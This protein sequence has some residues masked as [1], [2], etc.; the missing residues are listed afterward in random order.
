VTEEEVIQASEETRQKLFQEKYVSHRKKKKSKKPR[1]MIDANILVAGT[2]FPRFF[3][4]VLQHA[5]R[6]DFYLVLTPTIIKEARQ[7]IKEK[8]PQHLEDLSFFLKNGSYEIAPDPSPEE[9]AQNIDLIRDKK[10]IPMFCL[11]FK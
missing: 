2:I 5:L 4:E 11:Y 8:F 9:V 10:G 7:T 6:K 1:A 3:Y